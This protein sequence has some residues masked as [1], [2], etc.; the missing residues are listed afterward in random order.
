MKIPFNLVLFKQILNEIFPNLQFPVTAANLSCDPIHGNVPASILTTQVHLV[1]VTI[2][3][4]HIVSLTSKYYFDNQRLY[5]GQDY[6]VVS[7]AS[8]R[9]MAALQQKPSSSTV[10]F[11]VVSS[12]FPQSDHSG[13]SALASQSQHCFPATEGLKCN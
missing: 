11:S 5:D 2:A 6:L 4:V 3:E 1:E 9:Y 7:F 8:S 10:H 12:K 13:S